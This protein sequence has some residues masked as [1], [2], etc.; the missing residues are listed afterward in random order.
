MEHFNSDMSVSQ[1]FIETYLLNVDVDVWFG[2]LSGP[3]DWK[4][5]DETVVTYGNWKTSALTPEPDMHLCKRY[6]LH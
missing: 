3:S 5:L 6:L 4:F 1:R 2:A